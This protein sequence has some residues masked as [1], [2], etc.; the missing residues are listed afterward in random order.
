MSE[1]FATIYFFESAI[2]EVSRGLSHKKFRE[3][4]QNGG[5]RVEYSS[6]RIYIHSAFSL[7]NVLKSFSND[8]RGQA[9]RK[10]AF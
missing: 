2:L 3:A 5:E 1:R 6:C 9:G 8:F 7:E 10:N 4:H